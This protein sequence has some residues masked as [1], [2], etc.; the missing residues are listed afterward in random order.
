VVAEYDRYN[1]DRMVT[2]TANIENTYL[3]TAATQVANALKELG[4]P[5]AKVSVAIRGQVEPLTS[6]L[7]ALRAGLLT[8]FS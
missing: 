1:M 4:A 8:R 2:V 5:P 3:G 6:L 7:T